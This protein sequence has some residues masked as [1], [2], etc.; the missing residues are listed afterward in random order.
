MSEKLFKIEGKTIPE[1]RL[2]S[3]YKIICDT[4]TKWKAIKGIFTLEKLLDFKD[5]ESYTHYSNRNM[6]N[7]I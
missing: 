6:W 3:T 4:Y 2:M 1:G 5:K 7:I